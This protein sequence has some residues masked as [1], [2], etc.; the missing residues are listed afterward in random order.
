LILRFYLPSTK[1]LGP[2]KRF[3]CSCTDR[4]T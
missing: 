4:Q 3:R 2:F 1:T